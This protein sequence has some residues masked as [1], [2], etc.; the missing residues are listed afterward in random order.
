M[1]GQA[2]TI[3]LALGAFLLAS[4]VDAKLGDARPGSPAK[5][6]VHA[7]VGLV[8]LEGSVGLLYL[9]QGASTSQAVFLVAVFTLFLPAL[10]YTVLAALWL[11]RMLAEL[12]HFAGR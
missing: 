12:A 7:V 11:L 4:W 2:F 3:G 1:G 8:A 10:V 6:F 5:R 9:V